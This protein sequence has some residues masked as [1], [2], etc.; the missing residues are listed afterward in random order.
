MSITYKATAT[1]ADATGEAAHVIAVAKTQIGVLEGRKNGVWDNDQRYSKETPGL[2]WSNDQPW[3][4]TF[5][6]WCSWKAGQIKTV[7][8][9]ASCAAIEAYAKAHGRWSTKPALG[10]IV[11]YG[12]TSPEHCGRVI[13]YDASTITTIEGNTTTPGVKGG[14]ESNGSGVAL[15]RRPRDQWV[16][17]YFIPNITGVVSADPK[18]KP[19]KAAAP[20]KVTPTP[21]PAAAKATAT[22]APAAKK[23]KAVTKAVVTA[24][25][26]GKYG[27]GDDRVAELTKAGYDPKAV[28]A[29][30]NER[31]K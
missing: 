11:V 26:A 15:K 22:T 24:V 19:A 3:C 29:A 12:Y 17:G 21:K 23:P 2:A 28:Q 18:Y 7:P 16:I 8:V 30:V 6:V 5:Q 13:G 14:S 9:T 25:L 27:N 1:A 31:L 10:A 20:V 4:A